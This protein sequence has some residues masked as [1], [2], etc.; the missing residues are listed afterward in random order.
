MLGWER[1]RADF[2]ANWG[3]YTTTGS[4]DPNKLSNTGL[5]FWENQFQ[6]GTTLRLDHAKTITASVLTTWEL[7]QKKS[8][9]E[10]RPG[11]MFTA[12]FGLGKKFLKGGLNVGV[13]GAFYHKLSLDTGSDIAAIAQGYYDQSTQLG[14]EVQLILPLTKSGLYT[15]FLFRYQP[16]FDVAGRTHGNVLVFGA[17]LFQLFLPHH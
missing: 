1:G 5:G 13:S 11:N 14:P 12:E 3:F 7:N 10:N 17:T 9:L 16:Q 4:F 15:Q 8:G 6:L 2:T